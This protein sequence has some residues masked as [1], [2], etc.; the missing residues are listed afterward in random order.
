MWKKR[1]AA[2][3][4]ALLLAL[5]QSGCSVLFPLPEEQ[6]ADDPEAEI[7]RAHV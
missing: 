5:G 7:G 1:F 6:T 4:L 3:L 2:L